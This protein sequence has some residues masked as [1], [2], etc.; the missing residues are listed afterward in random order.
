MIKTVNLNKS[1]G[2]PDSFYTDVIKDISLVIETGEFVSIVGPS[3]SGKSTLLNLLSTLL[4]PTSGDIFF[5]NTNILAFSEKELAIFRNKT[6]GFIFQNHH[7]FPELSVLDNTLVPASIAGLEKN[8]IDKAKY[9]LERVGLT[10]RLNYKPSQI[11][12]GQCQRVAIARALLLSPACVF[13]DEPTGNLDFKTSTEIFDLLQELN[14]E[15]KMTIIM[16]THA[17]E[18]ALRSSRQIELLDGRIYSS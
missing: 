12:G 2:S 13:A 7:L 9:L 15:E 17:K 5:D 18:L 16:V 14:K 11:S 10:E 1:F 4:T 3:G 8:Y 6:I